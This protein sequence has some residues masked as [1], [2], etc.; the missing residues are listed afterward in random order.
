MVLSRGVS[1]ARSL[2][3]ASST[4]SERLDSLESPSETSSVSAFHQLLLQQR[5]RR[6]SLEGNNDD[7]LRVFEFSELKSATKCFSRNVLIG[8]GGFGC[9]YKGAVPVNKVVQGR[10]FEKM[11]VAVKQLNRTGFQAYHSSFL[12]FFMFLLF[13]ILCYICHLAICIAASDLL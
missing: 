6:K 3:F 9:V 8:E 1:W 4:R 5:N 7:D 11:D 10:S 13:L 2:S 12:L